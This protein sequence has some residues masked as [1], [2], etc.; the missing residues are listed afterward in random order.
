M[1]SK[2]NLNNI[3]PSEALIVAA[4]WLEK[5]ES[6][7]AKETK[8]DKNPMRITGPEIKPK[9]HNVDITKVVKEAIGE[10][11]IA[12]KLDKK[13]KEIIAKAIISSYSEIQDKTG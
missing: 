2:A 7:K 4:K 12:S 13:G 10:D 6:Y 5:I 3:K 11:P 9:I 1:I 8:E